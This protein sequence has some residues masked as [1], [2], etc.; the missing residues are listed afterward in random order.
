MSDTDWAARE[1]LTEIIGYTMN[2]NFQDPSGRTADAVLAAGYRKPRRITTR[3]E[4][5]A[6]PVDTV[7]L[8][9]T[10]AYQNCG[11][12]LWA[13]AGRFYG[14]TQITLPA[15]VLHEPTVHAA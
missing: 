14:S 10:I 15:Y 13:A 12:D 1:E 4:V 2:N 9:D 7:L 8:S 11:D 3:K 5:E 6:L